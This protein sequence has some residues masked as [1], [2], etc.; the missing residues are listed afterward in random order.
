MLSSS[1]SFSV[2]EDHDND[3]FGEEK[4]EDKEYEEAEGKKGFEDDEGPGQ[5]QGRAHSAPVFS[6]GE[7]VGV[8]SSLP[9]PLPLPP[10]SLPFSLPISI[11]TT[12][13]RDKQVRPSISQSVS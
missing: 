8:D 12:L 5:R 9:L 2:D 6:A 13:A 10:S 7:L 4:Y 11:E 1:L 3:D